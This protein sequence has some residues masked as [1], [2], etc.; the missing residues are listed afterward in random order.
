VVAAAEVI[1]D[2]PLLAVTRPVVAPGCSD[3]ARRPP[4]FEEAI[5]DHELWIGR[6][7]DNEIVDQQ[8]LGT[9][10]SVSDGLMID[11]VAHIWAMAAS[12]HVL[13]HAVFEGGE[14]TDLG[15]ITI[16]GDVFQGYI[17]PDVLRLPDGGIGLILTN[18]TLRVAGPICLLRSLDGQNFETVQV[19]LDEHGVQD[20]TVVITETWILAVAVVG[21]PDTQVYIGSPKVGFTP[22]EAVAGRD[23]DL[24]VEADGSVRLTV[25]E[26]GML[27]VHL[28]GDG[29]SWRP[30]ESIWS[31]TCGPA[32]ITGSDWILHLP[33]PGQGGA[34]PL[35]RSNP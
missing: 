26:G 20:P 29:V 19:L 27:K 4:G 3:I 28:S 12:D 33:K 34:L 14:F 31:Q 7:V 16:D 32:S 18:G 6:V 11:G 22:T 15:P 30:V 17:D 9:G 24:V 2:L 25:C 8:L 21:T 13:H 23:P 5:S 10:Y 1:A 35:K